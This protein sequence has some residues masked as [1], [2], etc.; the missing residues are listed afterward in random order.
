MTNRIKLNLQ[1][2]GVF[3]LVGAFQIAAQQPSP[4]PILYSEKTLEEL[5]RVQTAALQSDYAYR[6]RRIFPT[7]SERV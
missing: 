2:I 5:K 3:F 7:I 1:F 6:R 4:T